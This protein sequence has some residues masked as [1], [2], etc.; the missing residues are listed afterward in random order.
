MRRTRIPNGWDHDSAPDWR[1]ALDHYEQRIIETARR[2]Q[3]A[4]SLQNRAAP[5]FQPNLSLIGYE[6]R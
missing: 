6:R 1:Q 3:R 5:P 2:R 4:A